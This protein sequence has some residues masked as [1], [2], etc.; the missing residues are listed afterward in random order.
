MSLASTDTTQWERWDSML[1]DGRINPGQM[2]SFNHFSLG[3]VANFMHGVVGGL[4]S[5]E[6]GWSCALIR[7]QPGGTIR[8][9]SVTHDS[10]RGKYA[11]DW[12]LQG[13]TLEVKATIPPNGRARV[14]LPGLTKVFGSG[15]YVLNVPWVDDASWPPKGIPGPQSTK[16]P[17]EYIP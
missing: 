2:T 3:A 11:V 14:V 16:I 6:P 10:V 13:T 4:S 9:A 15:E 7:P 1:P 17:D 8:S 5:L 12:R